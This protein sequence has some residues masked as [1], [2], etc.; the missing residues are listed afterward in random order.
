MTAPKKPASDAMHV[1]RFSHEPVHERLTNWA[2]WT[3]STGRG[4]SSSPMFRHY[5]A[6][7]NRDSMDDLRIPVDGLD[8]SAIERIVASLPE[9]NRD[10][11]R[12]WYVY[13]AIGLDIWK[14]C[15]YLGVTRDGLAELVHDG[16]TM[17]KNRLGEKS[18]SRGYATPRTCDSIAPSANP[19]IKAVPASRREA[20]APAEMAELD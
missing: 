4:A 14:A 10:A 12:W 11:I 17:V 19:A 15:R 6:P 5:R 9:K 2:R 3:R 1:V 16:R 8:A 7:K 20:G 13:S 18:A